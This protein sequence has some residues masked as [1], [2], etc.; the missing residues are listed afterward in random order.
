M[1]AKGSELKRRE[2][3]RKKT[4]QGRE[5]RESPSWPYELSPQEKRSP[6][7]VRER[8]KDVPQVSLLIRRGSESTLCN[9][10][11]SSGQGRNEEGG[12]GD[13]L[14]AEGGEAGERGEGE[15]GDRAQR[16]KEPLSAGGPSWGMRAESRGE[17]QQAIIPLAERKRE[18]SARAPFPLL[19]LLSLFISRLLEFNPFVSGHPLLPI[20]PLHLSTNRRWKRPERCTLSPLSSNRSFLLLW[21]S[22]LFFLL[23]SALHFLPTA[24]QRS[25]RGRRDQEQ[26]AMLFWRSRIRTGVCDGL[27]A[28]LSEKKG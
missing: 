3:K 27:S 5:E 12:G 22:F 17:H 26:R 9:L 16:G 1:V 8:K 24:L 10:K 25:S 6:L 23:W 28:S 15:G 7:S 4:R 13:V 18:F 20:F 11:E 14:S 2:E 19:S 21:V